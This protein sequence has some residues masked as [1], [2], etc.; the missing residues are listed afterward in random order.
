MKTKVLYT[1]TA[2]YVSVLTMAGALT[3][4]AEDTDTNAIAHKS[5]TGTVMFV[6]AKEHTLRLDGFFTSKTFNLGDNC[7]YTFADKGAGAIGDLRPGQRIEVVYQEMHNVLVADRVTQE[8]MSSEG[9]VTACDPV[10]RTITLHGRGRDK[11]FPIA[12]DCKVMLRG[13]KSGSLADIQTG[14][15]VTVTYETPDDKPTARKITQTSETYTGSLTAIDLD[16]KTVKAKSLFDTKK[17]NLGDNCA[18]VI[19][20]KINGRLSD[21]KPNDKLVFSYDEING[22]NVASRIALVGRPQATETPQGSK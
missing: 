20:G 14:N 9:T 22:V 18:I 7:A 2:V 3:A 15:Y 17:F 4:P 12:G 21:L 5:Y 8:P 19:D 10:Q 16:T 6:D 11:T 13:D 1:W